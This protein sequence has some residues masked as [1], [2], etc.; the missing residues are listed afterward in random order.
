MSGNLTAVRGLTETK[1]Q[2]LGIVNGK[3]VSCDC[4]LVQGMSRNF[5]V[6]GEKLSLSWCG[7]IFMRSKSTRDSLNL[8]NGHLYPTN[9]VFAIPHS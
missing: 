1:T 8:C 6:L 3:P 7:N 2:K 5:K 9:R 4:F